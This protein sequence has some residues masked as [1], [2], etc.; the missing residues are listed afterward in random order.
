MLDFDALRTNP[1]LLK[2]DLYCQGVRLD[3][4]CYVER[5]GGRKIL[6]APAWAAESS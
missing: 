5:D 4:S 2:L 1:A 3:E 6:R